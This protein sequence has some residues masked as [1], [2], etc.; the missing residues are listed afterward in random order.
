MKIISKEQFIQGIDSGKIQLID[1]K[2]NCIINGKYFHIEDA[3]KDVHLEQ[4]E[5][6]KEEK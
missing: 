4:Y 6:F 5:V 1:N 2:D 3:R